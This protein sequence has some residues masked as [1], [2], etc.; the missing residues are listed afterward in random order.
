MEIS[1][2][3]GIKICLIAIIADTLLGWIFAIVQGKFDI[4]EAPRFLQTA[5]LP[6]VGSLLILAALAWL[7]EAY[8][9]IF[10]LITGIITAKF[11][12]EAIKDKIIGYFT[13]KS[14]KQIT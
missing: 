13:V 10:A 2:L 1:I 12:T 3:L 7:D 8:L 14:E 9:P 11:G 5:V 6:Y 4:R